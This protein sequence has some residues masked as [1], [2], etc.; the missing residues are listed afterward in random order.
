M[1]SPDLHGLMLYTSP[2]QWSRLSSRN[3]SLHILIQAIVASMSLSPSKHAADATDVVYHYYSKTTHSTILHIDLQ[4]NS[5][6]IHSDWLYCSS[7]CRLQT[8][9]CCSIVHNTESNSASI[10]WSHLQA[11]NFHSLR[12]STY[13]NCWG[14][15]FGRKSCWLLL[16][17][18]QAAL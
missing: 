10:T 11:S 18:E 6:M 3:P 15:E 2:L 17:S 5:L 13:T 7:I 9:T 4:S 12:H 8:S 14:A 16:L 1:S